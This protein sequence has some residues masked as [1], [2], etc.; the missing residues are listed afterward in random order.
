MDGT[1]ERRFAGT[2]FKPRKLPENA[3]PPTTTPA[4]PLRFTS[5]QV[6][7]SVAPVLSEGRDRVRAVLARIV[8]LEVFW[9]N[10]QFFFEIQNSNNN[11]HR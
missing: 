9:K 4:L 5:G 10:I 11:Y 8:V 6:P 1:G 2:N 7:G 3:P